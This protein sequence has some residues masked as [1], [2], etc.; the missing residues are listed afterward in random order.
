MSVVVGR[1]RKLTVS[2]QKMK[3]KERERER[4]SGKVK[5]ALTDFLLNG[6][7]QKYWTKFSEIRQRQRRR[8]NWR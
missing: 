2:Q 3:E 1:R 7:G 8:K 5:L 6:F 4:E